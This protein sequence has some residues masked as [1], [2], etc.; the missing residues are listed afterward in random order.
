M[1]D[2]DRLIRELS[3]IVAPYPGAD[4]PV[5]ALYQSPSLYLSDTHKLLRPELIDALGPELRAELP[6]YDEAV[7]YG[8]YDVVVDGEQVYESVKPGNLGNELTDTDYW[9]ETTILSSWYARIE[10][11][12]IGNLAL[13]LAGAPPVAAIIDRQPLYGKEA[14]LAGAISKTGRFVGIRIRAKKRRLAIRPLRVGLQ[15]TGPVT[16][17]PLYVFHS[18]DSAPVATILLTGSTSGRTVWADTAAKLVDDEGYYLIGYYESDLPVSVQAVGAERGWDVSGCSSCSGSDYALA[19]ARLPYVSIES[20]YVLNPGVSGVMGW[21]DEQTVKL[22]TWGLNLLIDVRCD[23]TSML[24]DNRDMLLNGLRKQ[25]A[26]DVLEEISTSTR[27]NGIAAGQYKSQA[28][29]ALNGQSNT[30]SDYGLRGEKNKVVSD[31][32]AVLAT[33]SDCIK[34][35]APRRGITM[36]T[37]FD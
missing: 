17:L 14:N 29:V 18:S 10:R 2:T 8:K 21:A 12:S 26:C 11:G 31:L 20:V 34:T 15:L 35:E 37:M 1:L 16:N 4:M 27:L 6:D 23:A 19:S 5:S 28:Y 25:I 13:E 24:L 33:V 7:P 9:Q 30:K 22:Q 32:K 3:G 36:G